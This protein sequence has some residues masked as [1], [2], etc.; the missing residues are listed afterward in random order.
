MIKLLRRLKDKHAAIVAIRRVIEIKMQ[1]GVDINTTDINALAT[2]S[3][4]SLNTAEEAFAFQT[5]MMTQYNGLV[6]GTVMETLAWALVEG[7]A[8]TE[9]LSFLSRCAAHPE[10]SS[11]L[12]PDGLLRISSRLANWKQQNALSTPRKETAGAKRMR[13]FWMDFTQLFAGCFP[14][15]PL[16]IQH[17]N[18][19][20][21]GSPHTSD[22]MW[23]KTFLKW[24]QS[25]N[26]HPD[27]TTFSIL[28]GYMYKQANVK[29]P[30][31]ELLASV[32]TV[33]QEAAKYGLSNAYDLVL[34]DFRYLVSREAY[35]TAYERWKN[36]DADYKNRFLQESDA[37]VERLLKRLAR[38]MGYNANSQL[39]DCALALAHELVALGRPTGAQ[40]N[41]QLMEGLCRRGRIDD[42]FE[43]LHA[44]R[45]LHRVQSTVL[46]ESVYAPLI[47][48]VFERNLGHDRA[49][50]LLDDLKSVGAKITA[51]SFTPFAKYYGTC[52]NWN[53]RISSM[54]AE[55]RT[56]NIAPDA[57]VYEA[58]ITSL[59]NHGRVEGALRLVEQM[60]DKRLHVGEPVY[61][62]F[63][64]LLCHKGRTEEAERF[65]SEV[66][67][68][69]IPTGSLKN[70]MMAYYMKVG[71]LEA[72]QR[73]FDE[74]SQRGQLTIEDYH[75]YMDFLCKQG[76]TSQAAVI[77]QQLQKGKDQ[78]LRPNEVSWRVLFD[79]YLK[80]T[81]E[82]GATRILRDMKRSGVVISSRMYESALQFYCASE[83]FVTAE[84]ILKQLLERSHRGDVVPRV[85]P[86]LMALART[87]KLSSSDAL[88]EIHRILE[89]IESHELSLDSQFFRDV[90]AAHSR[91]GA[92]EKAKPFVDRAL[93]FA[94]SN[95]ADASLCRAL[96]D[97]YGRQAMISEM[98]QFH[99]RI[100]TTSKVRLKKPEI[101]DSV[102]TA[103][104]MMT[105]YGRAGQF[106]KALALW[107][108]FWRPNRG[109]RIGFHTPT[110][111]QGVAGNVLMY[112]W[113]LNEFGVSWATVS[114]YFDV[115]GFAGK[116]DEVQ[117][118]W[119]ELK[120]S[121]FP[122]D[123]NNWTSYLEALVRC[124]L[125]GRAMEIMQGE[126]QLAGM[127]P[128]VKAVSNIIAM[129]Q[130]MNVADRDDRHA[131]ARQLWS[132]IEL[133]YPTL[134]DKVKQRIGRASEEFDVLTSI[135]R[136]AALEP[137][138]SAG[139]REA[140][141]VDNRTDAA[142]KVFPP[143]I[144]S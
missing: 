13:R 67:G 103:T 83:D 113:L 68:R 116:A 96:M 12:S 43:L 62:V 55:M 137:S 89:S 75:T 93:K 63:L 71:K 121:G 140:V 18:N 45:N 25:Y 119:E 28:V 6:D 56:L 118:A 112:R 105:G 131:Y 34:T 90:I 115:L 7:G 26:T 44:L 20:L 95:E 87:G 33:F 51:T 138:R 47:H 73:A 104:I 126:M 17:F 4:S 144:K 134:I 5:E 101:F 124:G 91:L 15:Q 50:E 10:V 133:R 98:E 132:Y 80:N 9:A 142:I 85:G 37:P 136:R 122:L 40:A 100:T 66:K 117:R 3:A 76:H 114:V 22:V 120:E 92:Y 16:P 74:A 125:V 36:L 78:K 39:M 59:A 8:Y 60:R 141:K 127:H 82:T 128:D 70:M 14:G 23:M 69:G 107:N 97:Y 108:E 2:V 106:D 111:L 123:Q 54:F 143:T 48:A 64:R 52:Q 139:E 61:A 31:N 21:R 19:I 94:D 35:S 109:S 38:R 84:S 41:A 30:R 86:L 32:D 49:R 46:N 27:S 99:K 58:L 42:A 79:G 88:A 65:L 29:T 130:N 110:Q 129:V 135:I 72:A 102:V 24:M 81:D 57:Y 11:W 53:E 1:S 77:F